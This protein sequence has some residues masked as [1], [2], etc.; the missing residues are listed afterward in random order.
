MTMTRQSLLITLVDIAELFE[1]GESSV[2]A[3]HN[4]I[5][6]AAPMV[7]E[8]DLRETRRLLEDAEGELESIRFTVD[9]DQR[10]TEASKVAKMVASH[11]RKV[12]AVQDSEGER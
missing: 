3:L 7:T 11:I 5:A 10:R 8:Y 1:R 6:L 2:E 9:S 4:A 12:I